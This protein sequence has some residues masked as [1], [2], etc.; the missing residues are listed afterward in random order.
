MQERC[1]PYNVLQLG[2]DPGLGE[3][4]RR[5]VQHVDVGGRDPLLDHPNGGEARAATDVGDLEP[6]PQSKVARGKGRGAHLLVPVPRVE[7]VVVY[8]QR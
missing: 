8:G 2:L 5:L 3:L 6:G 7:K 1:L 4:L